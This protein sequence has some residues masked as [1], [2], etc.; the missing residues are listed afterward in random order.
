MGFG[1]YW[2]LTPLRDR[3]GSCW[4]HPAPDTVGSPLGSDPG[5]S[6]PLGSAKPL[7][8]TAAPS[9]SLRARSSTRVWVENSPCEHSSGIPGASRCGS[10]FAPVC[11]QPG[12]RNVRIPTSS[13]SKNPQT[14]IAGV[15]GA[16]TELPG[17]GG[18]SGKGK[19]GQSPGSEGVALT[20]CP[21]GRCPRSHPTSHRSRLLLDAGGWERGS[22][23]EQPCPAR[24]AGG[25]GSRLWLWLWL[26]RGRFG[27]WLIRLAEPRLL[28]SSP[29][30]SPIHAQQSPWV[31]R[32]R[33]FTLS[34]LHKPVQS[35]ERERKECPELQE[36]PPGIQHPY[37]QPEGYQVPGKA[38]DSLLK[39]HTQLWQNPSPSLNS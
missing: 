34:P 32:K 21:E 19:R 30:S 2:W 13:R 35:R 17:Q 20:R 3:G 22:P 26:W 15:T 6:D 1:T 10:N 4:G 25:G 37:E 27:S 11:Q 38:S 28:P 31:M 33:C 9:P 24:R 39:V 5:G 16:G 12:Q 7:Q 14:L 36:K 18:H 23:Q 8:D 29:H